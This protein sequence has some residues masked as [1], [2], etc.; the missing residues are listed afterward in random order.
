[1]T[2]Q[3]L[4]LEL[5]KIENTAWDEAAFFAEEEQVL[6]HNVLQEL[7]SKLSEAVGSLPGEEA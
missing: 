4:K 3:E 2:K 6:A 5:S 1:M 7:A